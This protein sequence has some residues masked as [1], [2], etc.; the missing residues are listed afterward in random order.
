MPLGK[1]EWVGTHF[2]TADRNSHTG[3]FDTLFRLFLCRSK[4]RDDLQSAKQMLALELRNKETMERENKKLVTKVAALE[5]ELEK[6]KQMRQQDAGTKIV[7]MKTDED[8][9]VSKA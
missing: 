2:E 9:L 7:K 1:A 8:E 6:E 5:A 4:V 3:L